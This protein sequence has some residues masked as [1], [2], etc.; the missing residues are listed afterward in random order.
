M[1]RMIAVVDDVDVSGVRTHVIFESRNIRAA[2]FP[3]DWNYSLLVVAPSFSSVY[4][5]I[6]AHL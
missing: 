6:L 5:N 4:H 3:R 1:M 2:A